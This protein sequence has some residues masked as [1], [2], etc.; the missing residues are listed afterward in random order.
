MALQPTRRCVL[1]ALPAALIAAP[2]SK[3]VQF[4]SSSSN[5]LS[6]QRNNKSLVIYGDPDN[7]ITQ[8]EQVLVTH[9]R[10]DIT[11]S[12]QRLID[13]GATVVVPES[14]AN[15]FT[16]PLEAWR[17]VYS[18]TRLHDYANQGTHF[19][20]TP[21]SA[22]RA[23]KDKDQID[24]QGL[25]FDVIATPGY[26][27]GAVSYMT[28]VDNQRI[29]ATGDLIQAGGKLADI[30]SL[31]DAIP[32]LK[33]RGYHGFASRMSQLMAS[34]RHVASLNPDL[35]VPSRGAV[36]DKPQQAIQL[37]L[38]RLSAVYANYMKTDAYRWYFGPENYA[39][40]ARR[41][42]G[43]KPPSGLPFAE[44]IQKELPSWMRS[45]SNS[46]LVVSK[47]G[48]AILIDCGSQRIID[49]VRAWQ[50]SG[51]F[52]KLRAVYVTHYH[53]D[54]TD[55]AQAAAD[56]FGAELWSSSEQ[57]DILKNP[58]RYRMPCLTP[59]PI[60]G[61]KPWRD[62]ESRDWHEFRLQNFHFPGQTLYHGALL[63]QPKAPN[64][65]RVLFVGDSFTPSGADDYC[66]LN[67]NLLAPNQ[68]LLYCIGILESMPDALLVNQHV[69]PLFR[70]TPAQLRQLKTSLEE[71]IQLL[72]DLLPWDN[73]NFGVDEQWFRLAPYV[74]KVSKQSSV[75]IEPTIFNH[76]NK[77]QEF[78]IQ[79]HAPA[80]WL[81]PK[82]I[83]IR[84]GAGL[85]AT[86]S[87]DLKIPAEARGIQVVTA[88]VRVAQHDLRNW[89]EALVEIARS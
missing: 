60:P 67:R 72:T 56:Q 1:A 6:I 73:V 83:R 26:T 66:L 11:W 52:S 29:I 25:R 38:E 62:L 18:T 17:A 45:V 58:A 47:S 3:S 77:S 27:R 23:V 13:R 86:Q 37:L 4:Y 79:I 40:R 49:Q 65:P 68:G 54:H 15:L 59:N 9:A 75:L 89:A 41:I 84:V 71:R 64:A 12:A 46:R 74:Q 48:E 78:Q 55:F 43:D 50:T 70:F 24:W 44:T 63:V 14:E 57:Q 31:Q 30:Y 2:I 21:W 10:R 61:L 87:M 32:E 85:E 34:L 22:P 7:R 28:T 33:V 82:P 5:C 69:E 36:I 20:T 88:S 76:S 80:G 19:P 35:L 16:N 81:Q 42:L 39:A 53:D 51:V 8:A